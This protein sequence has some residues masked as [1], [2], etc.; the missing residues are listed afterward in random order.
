MNDFNSHLD[1]SN[2][3]P[4]DGVTVTIWSDSHACTVVKVTPT[5]VIVQRDKATR[6]TTPE[7][8]VGGFAGHCTNNADIEYSYERDPEGAIIKLS[9]R[10]QGDRYIW[11]RAGIATREQGGFATLGRSEYYDYNF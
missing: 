9:R 6:L 8:V 3:Q 7:F 10:R 4:G 2:V 11:K 1:L 5:T